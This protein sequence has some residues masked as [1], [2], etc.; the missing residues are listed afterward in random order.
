M[1]NSIHAIRPYRKNGLWV[2]DDD[3]VGLR[4]EPF[5]D[6]ADTMIDT[7]LREQ[8]IT[9]AD[10]GFTL[11]F[12]A[13]A[14]PGSTELEWVRPE[15]DGNVYRRVEHGDEAWLCPALMLYFGDPPP[16]LYFHVKPG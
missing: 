9:D 2:F 12:A 15:H 8:G 14:F 6:S 7:V 13:T 4:E 16:N 5:V 11:L 1:N 3:R 10:D